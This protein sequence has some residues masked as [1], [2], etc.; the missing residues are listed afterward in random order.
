MRALPI[1]VRMGL[2]VAGTSTLDAQQR[3]KCVTAQ[4]PNKLPS[5]NSL[6][7]STA[8]AAA[9]GSRPLP[10]NGVVFSVVSLMDSVQVVRLIEPSVV[11]SFPQALA[12]FRRELEP[13]KAEEV[14]AVRVRVRPSGA[15]ALE[16]SQYCPP[17]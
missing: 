17:M 14:W 15:I 9:F 7:D 4:R 2:A 5:V 12:I 6:L 10:A 1:A 11:D 3:Q 8:V 13:Q 16:R